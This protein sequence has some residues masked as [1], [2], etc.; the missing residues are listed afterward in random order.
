M[1]ASMRILG[2]GLFAFSL[3]G[4][5]SAIAKVKDFNK[6]IHEGVLV[7]K[8]LH[9]QIKTENGW[10]VPKVE[11]NPEQIVLETS[12]PDYIPKTSQRLLTYKKEQMPRK[13]NSKK[14]VER[15]ADELDMSAQGDF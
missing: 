15:V 10:K 8:Q 13:A 9:R 4:S 3:F 2:L 14:Q 7:R 12:V 6:M 11:S 1:K 5:I